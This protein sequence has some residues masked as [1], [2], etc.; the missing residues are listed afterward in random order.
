MKKALL[1]CIATLMAFPVFAQN[2]YDGPAFYRIQ[3]RGEAGR[4]ISITND[5][6]SEESKNFKPEIGSTFSQYVPTEALKAIKSKDYNPGTI[7]YVTG[8][9]SGL[10][11]TAQGINTDELLQKYGYSG[12]KLKVS[13]KG[14]LCTSY[15]GYQIDLVDLGYAASEKKAET[16]CGVATQGFIRDEEVGLYAQWDFKKI[17]N[18]NEFFGIYPNEGIETGGK[19]YTTLYTTFAYQL[20]EGTKAYYIDQ[21]NYSKNI[22]EPIARLQEI[23]DG[24]IPAKT[25]VIIEC[26]SNDV[27]NN[28]VTLLN[29]TLSPISENE[30]RGREFCFIPTERE[31]QSMKN[32][33]Q[34]D[35]GKMRV[36][37]LLDVKRDNSNGNILE[38]K[39]GFVNDANNNY[40]NSL[41]LN[42]GYI[43]ANKVYLP[44]NSSDATATAK[45]IKLLLPEE[46]AVATS[47]NKVMNEDLPAKE[48]VYTLTGVKVKDTNSIEDLP[49]GI[50]IIGGKKQVIK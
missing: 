5:K 4:F 26:S 50:Y 10:T 45:G 18:E 9:T 43:P 21:H 47:I 13:S 31:D 6:A 32:A 15:Q 11:L 37:G 46:Y 42:K 34:F 35:S 48:G 40:C 41:T 39:L 3:N 7:I 28:K 25:P 24:K 22:A 20:R 8:T 29:E 30:L 17:D 14:E 2:G 44:I 12:Y 19:Y 1:T 27:V 36:L 23:K 16:Y 38:A 49:S 33:L